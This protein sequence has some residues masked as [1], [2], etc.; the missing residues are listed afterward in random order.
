MVR[1][2]NDEDTY[3]LIYKKKKKKKKKTETRSIFKKED[4]LRRIADNFGT[5][6]FFNITVLK[7]KPPFTP[8]TLTVLSKSYP[9]ITETMPIP[10]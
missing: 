7:T 1:T 8:E 9:Y 2:V 10:C 4:K 3:I 6:F 5:I